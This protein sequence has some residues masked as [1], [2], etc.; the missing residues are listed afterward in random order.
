[1]VCFAV[2]TVLEIIQRFPDGMHT[3]LRLLQGNIATL[4]CSWWCLIRSCR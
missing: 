4:L 2:R 3:V 1:V